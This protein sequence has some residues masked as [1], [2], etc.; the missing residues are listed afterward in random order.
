TQMTVETIRNKPFFRLTSN[1]LLDNWGDAN[2]EIGKLTG[3][4][5]VHFKGAIPSFLPYESMVC[6][7]PEDYGI[8]E[9]SD[10]ATT[11]LGGFHGI[12]PN[13]NMLHRMLV[14][15][16]TG[17]ADSRKNTWGRPAPGVAKGDWK[18]PLTL[19]AK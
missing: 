12:L 17:A 14:R 19:K 15:Y 5:T 1:D 2:P 9:I 4:G 7:S 16:F 13:M 18:P 6:V 10:K 11:K 3:D 8:W